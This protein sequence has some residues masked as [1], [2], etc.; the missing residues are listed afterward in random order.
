MDIIDF[1]ARPNLPEYAAYLFPRLDAI[2]R[3]TNGSFGAFRPP[4]E[5]I[6]QFVANLDDAGIGR[7]LFAARNR[8]STG[9]WSLTNE[10]VADC[11]VRYP[12][13]IIGFGGVDLMAPAIAD[14]VSYAVELGLT[15]VCVDPFQVGADAADERLDPIYRTC[16]RLG[17]PV[18]V[19]LGGMPGIPA[20]LAAGSPLAL[21]LVAGRYPDLVIVGSH[22]GWPFVTEMIA[23]AWRRSNVYFENSFYHH[24]PGAGALVDAANTMIGHKMLYASA[25]PFTPLADTLNRFRELPF[26]ADVLPGILG[27]NARTVLGFGAECGPQVAS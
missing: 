16:V 18:V 3:D 10:L 9:G 6:D 7:A 5:T 8:S 23:V 17:I 13:R 14:Q 27:G 24:A 19:T 12:D 1:R 4:V 11:V 26:E 15:G 2:S 21:D 22:S 25:Y 20:P